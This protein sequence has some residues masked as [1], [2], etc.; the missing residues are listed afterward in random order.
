M[1]GVLPEGVHVYANGPVPER[2]VTV[3]EPLF[4]PQ[5]VVVEVAE[6]VSVSVVL[7]I[8][9]AVAVQLFASLTRTV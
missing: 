3:A 5:V 2:G 1:V 7:T 9:L 6:R 8:T 4:S